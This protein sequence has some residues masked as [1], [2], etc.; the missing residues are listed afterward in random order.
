MSL[1]LK[2]LSWKGVMIW[3]NT[4]AENFR[5]VP[6]ARHLLPTKINFIKMHRTITGS[7][8]RQAKEEVEKFMEEEG[9][10]SDR[11]DYLTENAPTFG[12]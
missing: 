9:W 6:N 8:L 2:D 7:G 1:K 3:M 10:S 4:Q 12:W 5:N 11:W